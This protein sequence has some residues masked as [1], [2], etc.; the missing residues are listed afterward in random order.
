MTLFFLQLFL[1]VTTN[2]DD[3]SATTSPV[4]RTGSSDVDPLSFFGRDAPGRTKAGCSTPA[5][6]YV[7]LAVFVV[8]YV[9]LRFVN[10]SRTGRA[11]RSLREDPLAA[12]VM[13]MPVNSLK[14]M[15]FAFGA[16]I[17]AL[18]RNV[19]HRIER[20]RLPALVLVRD[21]DHDLHDGD[22][23]RRRES[24]RAS[25]LG[26]V[27]IGILLE[28]LRDPGDSRVLF[29]CGHPRSASSPCSGSRVRLAV[30]ARRDASCSGSSS[31]RS[32]ARSTRLGQRQRRRRAAASRDFVGELGR[33]PGA[34]GRRGSHPSRTSRSSSLALRPDARYAAGC[35]SS[36]SCP[37]LY[38]A[39]FVWENVMLAKPEPTRY[40]ILGVILDRR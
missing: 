27:L 12:E 19:R 29:Y 36:C 35:G 4:A 14:L 7:V 31:M 40:I 24:G 5:Y 39:A 25:S 37:V 3:L 8:V 6:L 34:P 9:A 13:G 30:V 26:A 32:R 22:P 33:R 18:T 20:Q 28:V 15:S 38:L 1:T 21:P 16:A 11:W 17:A 10:L 23:R 2:G